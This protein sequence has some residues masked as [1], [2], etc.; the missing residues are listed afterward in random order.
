MRKARIGQRLRSFVRRD[1][2]EKLWVLPAW[3]GLGLASLLI[4]ALE[5]KQIATRLGANCGT[6]KP[7]F[8]ISSAEQ[9]RAV[10]IGRTVQFAAS[11]APWRSNCYPQAIVAR[12]LLSLYGLPYTVSMGVRRDPASGEI[13]AHTWVECGKVLVTGGNSDEYHS[14]VGVFASPGRCEA[15]T[16]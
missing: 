11:F 1:L 15:T 4:W 14:I 16:K 2:F 5:F 12:F 9:Q 8:I 6:T 13:Y 7:T 3:L 10:Q